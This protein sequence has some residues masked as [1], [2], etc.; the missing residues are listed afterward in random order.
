MV[1]TLK[2]KKI[3][4]LVVNGKKYHI[5]KLDYDISLLDWIRNKINLKGTKEGCNEGDCGA[6]SVLILEK[7]KHQCINVEDLNTFSSCS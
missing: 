2:L 6:C 4:Q 3:D 7:N 1:K 5:E